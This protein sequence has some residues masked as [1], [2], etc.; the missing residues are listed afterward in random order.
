MWLDALM[1]EI[2]IQ[3]SDMVGGEGQDILSFP[4]ASFQ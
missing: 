3:S 4:T 1:I 2:S